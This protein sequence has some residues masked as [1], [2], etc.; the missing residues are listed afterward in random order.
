MNKIFLFPGQGCQYYHMGKQLYQ[1]SSVFKEWI[2]YGDRLCLQFIK[3][4][5]WDTVCHPQ[6]KPSDPLLCILTTHPAIFIFEYAMVQFLESKGITPDSVLGSS[7]GEFA[8]SVCAERISYQHALEGIIHQAQTISHLC[9]QGGMLAILSQVELYETEKTLFENSEIASVNF[10]DGFVVSGIHSRLQHIQNE[11]KSKKIPCQLLPVLYAFHS[12]HIEYA[13]DLHLNFLTQIPMKRA[14]IPYISTLDHPKDHHP[15]NASYFWRVAR[16]A[17]NIKKTIA[18]L[19]KNMSSLYI[20]L[21][22]S[23]TFANIVKYN[24]QPHSQ[25]KTVCT[26]NPYENNLKSIEKL[27]ALF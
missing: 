26:I 13:K 8:A 2:D 1:D 25:S 10:N 12:R 24:L 19:E 20:D 21:G 18:D 3:K 5:V 16:E 23:G 27:L 7:L 11:L 14:Q 15:E 4:S 22:P 9:E 17:M 6:F